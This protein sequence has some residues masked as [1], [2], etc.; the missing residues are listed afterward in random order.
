MIQ[1]EPVYMVRGGENTFQLISNPRVPYK[2]SECATCFI[3][4]AFALRPNI[5]V[6]IDFLHSTFR[7]RSV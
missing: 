3:S 1:K 7:Y 5:G 4:W 2:K 6:Y